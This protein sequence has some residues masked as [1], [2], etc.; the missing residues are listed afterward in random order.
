MHHDT[1]KHPKMTT[2]WYCAF[3]GTIISSDDIHDCS[4]WQHFTS[5]AERLETMQT[6][7]RNGD[8]G[9]AKQILSY[10]QAEAAAWRNELNDVPTLH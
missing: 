5:L 7:F 1:K 6:A 2:M 9:K 4:G 10:L 8:T 3:C